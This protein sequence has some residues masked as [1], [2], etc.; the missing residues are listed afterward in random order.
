MPRT[1][2]AT[3]DVRVDPSST[4][5]SVLWRWSRCTSMAPGPYRMRGGRRSGGSYRILRQKGCIRSE[6]AL[7][8]REHFCRR[9]VALGAAPPAPLRAVGVVGMARRRVTSRRQRE[10]LNADAQA[11]LNKCY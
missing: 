8:E 10:R 4:A 2:V 5:M 3:V 1:G 7:R 9:A 11:L 6:S